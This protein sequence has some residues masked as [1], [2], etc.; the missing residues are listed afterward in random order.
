MFEVHEFEAHDFIEIGEHVVVPVT[1][2]IRGRDGIEVTA[3]TASLYTVRGDRVARIA[4]YQTL[5]EAL[6]AAELSE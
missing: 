5:E 6:Q 3:D 4:M 2:R 1:T